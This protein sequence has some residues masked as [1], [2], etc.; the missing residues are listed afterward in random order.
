MLACLDVSYRDTMAC[1]AGITFQNWTDAKPLDEKVIEI[2]NV[3]PYQPGHFYRRELPCLLAILQKLPPID[4][5]IID[6]Y[7]WLDGE[8]RPGL[9]AHLYHALNAKVPVVGVAKT[10]FHGADCVCEVI[11]G[12]SKRPLFIT[13]AGVQKELAAQHVRSMHG[14]NRLP[15]LLAR[16]D[17]LCRHGQV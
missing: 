6:G 13:A 2:Q 4:V 11:R 8:S 15:T 14:K 1:A 17:Y 7:V 16:A 12:V 5:A 10:K 9:G 3:A